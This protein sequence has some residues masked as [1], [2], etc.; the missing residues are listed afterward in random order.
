MSE[1]DR[2]LFKADV[3]SQTDEA[4]L[5]EGVWTHPDVRGRGLGRRALGTLCS[6]LLNTHPMVCLCFREGQPGLRA[7]YE[8]IG[9]KHYRELGDYALVRYRSA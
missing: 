8:G 3:A 9:F 4:V 7:F 5:L 1:A 2:I 6:Q